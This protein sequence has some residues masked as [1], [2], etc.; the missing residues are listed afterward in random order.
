[1]ADYKINILAEVTGLEKAEQQIR[2]ILKLNGETVRINV[3][4]GKLDQQIQ[5]IQKGMTSSGKV[6]G[7]N[8]SK[9]F[10]GSVKTI[11][12]P[13]LKEVVNLN[14]RIKSDTEKALK[15][16]K[17]FD[18]GID[19]N[20]AKKSASQ[21]VNQKVKAEQ[22]AQAEVVKIQQQAIK[23]Q[24][25]EYTALQNKA[26][27]ILYDYQTKAL[28]VQDAQMQAGIRKY[29]GLNQESIDRYNN[30]FSD[31]NRAIE[32]YNS[33]RSVKNMERL[34]DLN[35][36]YSKSMKTLGNEF[37][38]ASIKGDDLV[39][40]K[41][42]ADFQRGLQKYWDNNNRMHNT[43]Y[44]KNIQSMFD[45]LNSG[46]ITNSQ[47]KKLE[48]QAA[49]IKKSVDID[50]LG[51]KSFISTMGSQLKSVGQ[52]LS[53]YDV[54]QA[55]INQIGNMANNVLDINSAMIELRKVSTASD[56]DIADYYD[57][58]A[59]SAKKYGASID[60]VI[61]S[62]AD[63]SRLGYGLDEAKELSNAT[64][65][66]QRVGDNMT[67]E[68]S[69]Q[70]LI[71]TLKGFSKEADEATAIVDAANEVANT[72]PIDTAGIFSALQRSASSLSAAGNTYQESMAMITA[73]NS[74]VQDPDTVGTAFKTM[75]MRIRGAS[76]ELQEAGLDTEGM[77]TSTAK[78]REEMI[79][80]SGVDIMKDPNT[81]KSTYQI[82]D[83]LADRWSGLTDIQQAN[84]CLSVQKCA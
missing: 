42:V 15:D 37:K 1:M 13:T 48:S 22:K 33:D 70:G 54:I 77:A 84:T 39:S 8:F 4:T 61:N 56:V 18:P 36:D 9:G 58:A 2:N 14:K 24:E 53:T 34:V 57:E 32:A 41:K 43:M 7:T 30:A 21:Y 76:T 38:I 27:K 20:V 40:A 23:Q 17:I 16:I 3:E 59:A 55:G 50:G 79:A 74:V 29:A 25:K 75:S 83:E 45:Q 49:N 69:S 72:Q 52:M 35:N 46:G 65:L 80:L 19:Q 31:R 73:A 12:A 51:G 78:L 28:Q 81:F 10:V 63:W 26:D 11:K 82:L 67:Q 62:T 60:E 71:S 44:G 5:Q 47:M 66:L 64:T 6:S 68:S